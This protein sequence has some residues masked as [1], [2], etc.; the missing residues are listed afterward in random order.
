MVDSNDGYHYRNV[1]ESS[2]LLGSYQ[3]KA[4][5]NVI[6]LNDVDSDAND[7]LYREASSSESRDNLHLHDGSNV[8][9]RWSKKSASYVTDTM[10]FTALCSFGNSYER[11]FDFMGICG[12]VSELVTFFSI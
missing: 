1:I 10:K 3:V 5:D 11:Q 2:K 6:S 9:I 4:M 12:D 7:I 8:W